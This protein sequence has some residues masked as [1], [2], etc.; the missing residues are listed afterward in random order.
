MDPVTAVLASVDAVRAN[1]GAM[2]LWAALIAFLTA[3]GFAT[4]MIGLIMIFPLLAHASWHCYRDV[5]E[6]DS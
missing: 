3:I 4:F 1:P 6:P 5:V 2:L